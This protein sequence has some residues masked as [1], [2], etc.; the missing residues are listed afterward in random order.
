MQAGIGICAG[1]RRMQLHGAGPLPDGHGLP[2]LPDVEFM[3]VGSETAATGAQ[4][5]LAELLRQVMN[6]Q[7]PSV[8]SLP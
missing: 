5:A 1:P 7:F 3:M 2:K 6:A 4:A 8:E